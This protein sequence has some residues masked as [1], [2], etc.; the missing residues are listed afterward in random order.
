MNF[1]SVTRDS[2]SV[3]ILD[4]EQICFIEGSK[5]GNQNPS[6]E[7]GLRGGRTLIFTGQNEVNQVKTKLNT[8]LANY[9][10]SI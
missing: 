1:V 3:T 8:H 2:G 7:I 4:L 6:I 10:M 5:P 9:G